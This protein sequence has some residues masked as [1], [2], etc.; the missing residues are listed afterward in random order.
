MR[1]GRPVHTLFTLIADTSFTGGAHDPSENGRLSDAF[2]EVYDATASGAFGLALR[3]V[4]DRSHAEDVVQEAYLHIWRK[5]ATFDPQRG[6]AMGWIF[7]VVHGK[8]STGSARPSR[9]RIAMRSFSAKVE[10]Q[11]RLLRRTRRATSSWRPLRGGGPGSRSASSRRFNA[12][13]S[14]WRISAAIPAPRSPG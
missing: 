1:D 9:V 12:S 5:G 11:N 13:Q 10:T 6:T 14:S 2:A 4:R 7:M 3:V 8:R